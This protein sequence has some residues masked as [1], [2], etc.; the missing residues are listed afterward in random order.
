MRA[1]LKNKKGQAASQAVY[2]TMN[3]VIGLIVA[4]VII[5]T[6]T[7]AG[8]LTANSAED[9][10]TDRIVGNL[11]TGIDNNAGKIATIITI[12]F[13]VILLGFLLFLVARARGINM[14]GGSL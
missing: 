9:N 1:I 13:V 12:A 11:T 8:L 6:I 3:F 14:G 7:G 2:G 4:F 5:A 10:A